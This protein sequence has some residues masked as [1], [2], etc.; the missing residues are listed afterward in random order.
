M[1]LKRNVYQLLFGFPEDNILEDQIPLVLS[2]SLAIFSLVGSVINF[3]LGLSPIMIIAPL[4]SA[5]IMFFVYYQ[6][7][8]A[9]NKFLYKVIM[10]IV[11]YFFFNFLWF[12][13]SA[14]V[15]PTLFLFLLYF[16]FIMMIFEKKSRILFSALLMINLLLL[17]IIEFYHSDLIP[18]YSNDKIR[19]LDIYSSFFMYLAFSSILVLVVK[20]Y[21]NLERKRSKKSDQLKSAFLSNMSHEIRTP[22]S[23]ILG[24]SKLLDYAESEKERSEYVEI[25][26]ENG[27]L[28]MQ[29]LDDII[30][31]SRMDVGQFDIYTKVFSLN[32]VMSELKKVIRLSLDQQHKQLV[33]L[34]MIAKKGDIA[35]QSDENRLRQILYNL[36]SNAAK[37]TSKGE[38]QFG[39]N[40]LDGKDI[41]FYV[42]DTGIGIKEEHK[43]EIFNRFYKVENSVHSSLPSGSGIGLSIV[44][45]LIEKMGGS[46]SFDSI[47]GRGSTFRFVL[48]GVVLQELPEPE[49]PKHASYV[50][51]AHNKVLVAEDD[52][53]NL[54]L[55]SNMLR[56]MGLSCY[57]AGN[58]S[59]ALK[60]FT[61]N[62]GINLVLMDINMPLMNG[63]VA[64][65]E[66]K[67]INP[68]IPVIAL[69]AYA[70]AQ[71]KEKAIV[72]GFDSY[73]T[74]P[75]Y[76]DVL[77]DC[78]KK[79]L[80]LQVTAV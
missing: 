27:K 48:P 6:S 4:L 19:I 78:L 40:L 32:S 51:S 43:N 44:K 42:S 1:S 71:D 66:M 65:A 68:G 9:K 17:F 60:V 47:Y 22:M 73:L 53:S 24:F 54:K 26:N 74:K 20:Y 67:K 62:P 79:Y 7:L 56:K 49:T 35:I 13:N 12:F 52:E 77:A 36:L 38:I 50:F 39:Y 72:A 45:M 28:L 34:K 21:Y 37:F 23:A 30:D 5:I 80:I 2:F 31:I 55:I 59:E 41:E 29:L 76:Q 69:T 14:S 11:S 58:G 8:R 57:K 15:G 61:E 63:L 16:F 25:I 10:A 70:M 46:L 75:I 64:L 18:P 3:F 33:N